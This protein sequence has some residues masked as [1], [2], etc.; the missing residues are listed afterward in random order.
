ME[1]SAEFYYE[2]LKDNANPGAVLAALYCTLYGSDVTRS[3]IIMFNKLIKVFGRFIVFF[4]VIDMAGSYPDS[5]DNPYSLLYT[6]CKRKFEA[7]HVNGNLQ[8]RE[9]L[10][11]FL[12]NL[13]REI[14]NMNL[15]RSKLPT[16]K[17]LEPDGRE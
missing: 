12:S 17:G 11:K 7:T 4:S 14:E 9:P 3:E 13:D 5:V 6:I 1:N 2:K 8:S 15:K 16:S 10:N